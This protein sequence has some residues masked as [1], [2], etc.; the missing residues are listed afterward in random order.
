MM[1]KFICE[2]CGKEFLRKCIRPNI[3]FCSRKC[4]WGDKKY[5]KKMIKIREEINNNPTLSMLK[6]RFQKGHEINNGKHRSISTEFKKG[7]SKTKWGK[8]LLKLRGAKIC[9]RPTKPELNTMEIINNLNLENEWKYTG[10]GDV[11]I[12]I[13]NPDFLNINGKK[14]IIEVFSDYWHNEHRV[15]ILSHQTEEG[16]KEFY[17]NYGFETLIIWERELKNRNFVIEKIRGFTYG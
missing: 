17:K 4:H 3:R 2:T 15:G 1:Y 7:W 11:W 6:T 5:K 9:K 13:K 16:T 8:R 14:K 10:N 12:G